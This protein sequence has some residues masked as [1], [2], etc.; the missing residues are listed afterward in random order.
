M[1]KKYNEKRQRKQR[2]NVVT[3]YKVDRSL[4]T[5]EV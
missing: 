5:T 4:Y 2:K 1:S 3:S